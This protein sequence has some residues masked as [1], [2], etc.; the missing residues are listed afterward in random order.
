MLDW[1]Y[2]LLINSIAILISA[3]LLS[4]VKVRGF[5]DALVAAILLGL[6]NA[7]IRPVLLLLTLPI[8]IL[9]F[10]LFVLVINALMVML[11]A[12]ILPGVTVKNFWW[13]LLFSIILTLINS[14]LYWVF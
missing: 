8:T 6:V 3:Y 14:F 4:G 2:T 11:V 7:F 5:L 12:A 10:G 13:A 1:L 9:T